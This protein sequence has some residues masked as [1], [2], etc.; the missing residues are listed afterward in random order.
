MR[1]GYAR[2]GQSNMMTTRLGYGMDTLITPEMR[3]V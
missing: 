2:H 1:L 3:Y